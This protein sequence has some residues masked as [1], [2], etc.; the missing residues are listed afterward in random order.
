MTALRRKDAL[1]MLNKVP[2]VT[3][4][5]WVVKILATTVGETGADF[6]SVK[7]GFGLNG[8]SLVMGSLLV[9]VLLVHLRARQYIPWLY[10]VTVVL[11]SV[12]GTLITD[13]L[14][15]KLGVSLFV[16]TA[17]F[18]TALAATFAA[19]YASERTLSVHT[20]VTTRRELFYWAAI[21]FT[22]ALGTAGGDLMAEKLQLGYGPSALI[23]ASAIAAIAAAFYV[24]KANAILAFWAAYVLTRPLGASIGDLLSQQRADGGLGLGTMGTSALFLTIITS[25][26][27]FMSLRANGH[28][29][30]PRTA[31]E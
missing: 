25:L 9:A 31:G 27:V 1:Q 10:W 22:F 15:D 11:M 30:Q 18:S 2:E 6:L 17:A 21:L 24:L 23:F 4:Y 12:V 28:A 26:V 19:W 29:S 8:T 20:I 5:F 7:L 16:S 13:N 3:L 14:T